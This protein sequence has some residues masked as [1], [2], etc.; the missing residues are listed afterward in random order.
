[1]LPA[2]V[3]QKQGGVD[4]GDLEVFQVAVIDQ[5]YLAGFLNVDDELRVLMG[6]DDGS[7]P[8][9]GM[10]LPG[11]HRKAT[12]RDDLPRLESIAVH[13][14]EL[15]RPVGTGDGQL[16]LVSLV[17]RSFD[18]TGFQADLDFSHGLRIFHPQ[19]DEIDPG[20]AADHEKVTSRGRNSRNVHRIAGI[21]DFDKF[22]GIAIDEGDLTG[23]AQRYRDQIVEV[24]AV[25]LFCRF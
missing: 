13:Q 16:V 11:I 3:M 20:V 18:G 14:H 17:L 4:G 25:L 1:M 24:I 15:W 21:D 5:F 23:V 6:R 9:F 8:G 22:L 2:T 7:N 12:G 19:I 10:I